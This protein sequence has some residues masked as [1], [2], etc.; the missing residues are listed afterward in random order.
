MTRNKYITYIEIDEIR[1]K[2]MQKVMKRQ[3]WTSKNRLVF[4]DKKT[5][6]MLLGSRK[7]LNTL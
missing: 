1:N 5:K 2:Y 7:R 4:N 3:K 6:M